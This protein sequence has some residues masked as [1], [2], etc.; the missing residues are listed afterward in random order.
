MR[1]VFV[2][3]R[4]NAKFGRPVEGEP[5]ESCMRLVASGAESG[6]FALIIEARFAPASA[7]GFDQICIPSASAAVVRGGSHGFP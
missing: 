6:K 4:E 1:P 3:F 2:R 7:R 5:A